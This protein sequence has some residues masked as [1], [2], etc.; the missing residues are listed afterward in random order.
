PSLGRDMLSGFIGAM[1]QIA[2]CISFS[3]LIFQDPIATGFP[4]GIAAL[5]M[6]TVITGMVVAL[7]TTLSPATGGPDTPAVA[8]LSVLAGSIGDTLSASG[9][10]NDVIVVNALVAITVGTVFSGIFLYGLG[11]LQ[12]GQWLRFVPYPVVAGFL[13]GSAVLMTAGGAEVITQTNL[14]LSPS[15]WVRLYSL[16]YVPQL[17]VGLLFALLIA[18]L[19]RWVPAYLTLPVAF[20][21]ILVVLDVILFSLVPSEV[22]AIWFLPSFGKLTL[23]WPLSSIT[24]PDIYWGVIAQKAGDIGAL[25]LIT[26]ISMLLDVSSLE[27]ARQKSADLDKELRTNGIANIMAGVLGGMGGNLSL[28]GAIMLEESGAI[29]RWGGVFVAL[30][31]AVILFAGADIGTYVPKAVLGGMLFYLGAIILIEVWEAPVQLSWV[32]WMFGIAIMLVICNFGYLQG[33]GLGV[34]VACL[35]FALNYSRIGVIRRDL[36]RE[37]CSSNVERSREQS[38]LLQREGKRIHELWLSG[39]IFFGSCNVIFERIKQIVEQQQDKP[40]EYV[41]LDFSRIQGLDNSAAR[42]LIKLRDFCDWNGVVL[43]FSG[44]NERVRDC[45]EQIRFFTSDRSHEVFDTRNEAIE[46]CEEMLLMHHEVGAASTATFE[47]WLAAE[48]G[49]EEDIVRLKSYLDLHELR[50][51][52]LLFRQGEPSDSIDLIVSGCVAITVDDENGKPIKLRRMT[53]HTIVGE[54]GFY[55]HAPRAANVVA[56]EATVV[57]RLPKRS[58]DRLERE[59]PETAAAFHQLIVRVLSDRLEFA[60]REISSL[61]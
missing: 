46:W 55:R 50:K 58:F 15:S 29:T 51:G 28:N 20:V 31:C 54:M 2:Y 48:V 30:T 9:V 56:E 12:W 49:R 44:F 19:R 22:R 52:E 14:T 11:A 34:V 45:F 43:A 6:G 59:H 37:D 23:W 1:V 53:G 5:L 42:S 39:F 61:S 3:A 4:L 35:M 26:A 8:V 32:D 27:V 60:N 10:S 40:L 13:A 17:G 36:S 18:G 7:T 16:A 38:L 21:S 57:Y 47:K 41:G 33:V 25:S 24:R